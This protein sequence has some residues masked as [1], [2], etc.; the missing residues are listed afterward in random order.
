[1]GP[2]SRARVAAAA[3]VAGAGLAVCCALFAWARHSDERRAELERL[4]ARHRAAVRRFNSEPHRSAVLRGEPLAGPSMKAV[5]EVLPRFRELARPAA[6]RTVEQAWLD[7]ERGNPLDAEALALVDAHRDALVA[8]RRTTQHT[9]VGQRYPFVGSEPPAVI[10][11]FRAQRLLLIDAARRQPSDCLQIAADVIRSGQGVVPGGGLITHM[12]FVRI[13]G[14]ATELVRSCAARATAD[15]LATAH[16]ELR[17]LARDAPV[18]AHTMRF[19]L[20]WGFV[21]IREE[22]PRTLGPFDPGAIDWVL[23]G[24][25]SLHAMGQALVEERRWR[26]PR[27][28]SY[29]AAMV[30]TTELAGR[31]S[32]GGL[33]G[34]PVDFTIYARRGAVAESRLRATAILLDALGRSSSRATLSTGAPPSLLDPVLADPAT[35]RPMEYLPHRNRIAWSLRSDTGT[36]YVEPWPW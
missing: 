13:A 28:A 1:M 2:S 8:L 23:Q 16:R 29:R 31:Y 27:W 24:R 15:D 6:K 20:L 14:D 4:E 21:A 33:F 35:D 7:I 5:S 32:A 3:G 18:F 36:Q 34:D 22:A 19:E 30:H 12:V 9:T 11:L 26:D 10:E 25:D 17:Q